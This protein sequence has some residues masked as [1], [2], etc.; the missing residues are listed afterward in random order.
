MRRRRRR[1]YI[2][3]RYIFSVH[4]IREFPTHPQVPA[5]RRRR[6]I[7]ETYFATTVYGCD[8]VFS[9]FYRRPGR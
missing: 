7:P 9:I 6:E 8:F 5:L 4:Q 1:R 2:C 3:T